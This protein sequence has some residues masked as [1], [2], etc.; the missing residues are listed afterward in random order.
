MI[1]WRLPCRCAIGAAQPQLRPSPELFRL[2][3]AVDLLFAREDHAFATLLHGAPCHT[4]ERSGGVT[5]DRPLTLMGVAEGDHPVWADR[6]EDVLGRHQTGADVM[7]EW[8]QDPGVASQETTSLV[9]PHLNLAS[10]HH[11][12][13]F[14]HR[15]PQD[16]DLM[17]V[18]TADVA[19]IR[20]AADS[21]SRK[22]GRDVNVSV[23]TPDEWDSSKAGFVAH[24][25]AEPLV[26][27]ELL[28]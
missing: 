18:G 11:V 14:P 19:E 3:Q 27:L 24:L 13:G 16:V 25:K 22:L 17:I 9:V 7:N 2:G 6:P 5:D 23:L 8:V 21:A 15:L 26:E 4:N 12:C 20:A 28:Q 1:N 10:C